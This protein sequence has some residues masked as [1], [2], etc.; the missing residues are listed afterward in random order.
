MDKQL[1]MKKRAAE[2]YMSF[3]NLP[4]LAAENCE[5]AIQAALDIIGE[6]C[7][8]DNNGYLIKETIDGATVRLS[9]E[10]YDEIIK[11]A[12]YGETLDGLIQKLL[13]CYEKRPEIKEYLDI[14]NRLRVVKKPST[15]MRDSTTIRISKKTYEMLSNMGTAQI[16]F[17][18][19]IRILIEESIRTDPNIKKL[20]GA[21]ERIKDKEKVVRSG[22]STTIS[23]KKPT[24][25]RL[26]KMGT[27]STSVEDIINRML[28]K[29]PPR[30]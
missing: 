22:K 3:D 14:I 5:T 8:G 21:A 1:S 23:L 25:D 12:R 29:C 28:K 18:D 26:L 11:H 6:Q 2:S 19:I 27:I 20:M 4:A 24:Y 17:D 9:I 7:H 10:S 16:T 30:Y 13:D 15:P